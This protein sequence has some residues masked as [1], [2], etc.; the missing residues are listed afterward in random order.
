[1]R[2]SGPAGLL[3]LTALGRRRRERLQELEGQ[4]LS[5]RRG[6]ESDSSHRNSE[7]A[8]V[9]GREPQ[10]VTSFAPGA[11]RLESETASYD[12]A[13]I[14]SPEDLILP[15]DGNLGFLHTSNAGMLGLSVAEMSYTDL[16]PSS[17]CH[18]DLSTDASSSVLP[19]SGG[20]ATADLSG[21]SPYEPSF[22]LDFADYAISTPGLSIIR[23]HTEIF[24]QMHGLGFQLDI[25]NPATVSPISLGFQPHTSL[26]HYMPTPLQKRI[27]H[28]PIVDMLPWPSFRDRFLYVMSLPEALRP[29]IAQKDMPSVTLELMFA[30]KDAGGGLRVW[31]SNPF[32]QESWEIGQTF[33]SRFWWAID[34]DIVRISNRLRAER[35]ESALRFDVSAAT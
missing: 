7:V 33:Y 6:G 12:T 35:G 3:L 31:G 25:F 23:A 8:L 32:S 34:G 16:P 15:N 17:G 28:H 24:H 29:R 20:I 18:L 10:I 22:D 2:L 5:E 19:P 9:T 11:N 21:T 13:E 14:L 1:M 4:R 30:V 27:Q 26:V